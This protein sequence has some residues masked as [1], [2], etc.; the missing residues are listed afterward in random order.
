VRLVLQ[1][2]QEKAPDLDDR[3]I[4][5]ERRLGAAVPPALAPPT[6]SRDAA[7]PGCVAMLGCSAGSP[8]VGE[9]RLPKTEVVANLA[10]YGE[11]GLNQHQL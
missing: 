4:A 9:K 10:Q 6:P 3:G 2:L 11:A 1:D 8:I 5:G 7:M